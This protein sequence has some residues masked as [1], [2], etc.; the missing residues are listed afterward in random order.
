[1][2]APVL[3]VIDPGFGA[4]LQDGGRPGWRRYGVPPSGAM[5]L[6]AARTANL[7]VGNSPDQPVLELL[8]QGAKLELLRE[9]WTAVCGAEAGASIASGSA[10]LSKRGEFL[11]FPANR[12][13]VWIYV[14]IAGGLTGPTYFG[15]AS[16]YAAGLWGRA[17]RKGDVLSTSTPA[18]KIPMQVAGRFPAEGDSLQLEFPLHPAPQTASFPHE[19]RQLL[20][21]TPWIIDSLSDR[22]GYRLDGPALPS[23]PSILSEGVLPGSL[24]V[25][26]NGRPIV[27]MPDG[28]TVGGYP[29]IACL[30]DRNRWR[31]AQ[32]RPGTQIR[33]RWIG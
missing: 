13:G 7:L 10:K 22:S 27:T 28:P 30:S 31:L 25:P 15:S 3:R 17:L 1:M 26:G 14:A 20:V 21:S 4:T 24:Q 2:S 8:L 11:T 29:K 23:A 33:F 18:A 6:A 16:V 9:A 19:A 12:S 5:D 32:C